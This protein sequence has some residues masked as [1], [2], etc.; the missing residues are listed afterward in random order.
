MKLHVLDYLTKLPPSTTYYVC[1]DM[2][3]ERTRNTSNDVAGGYYYVTSAL[4]VRYIFS[5]RM[6]MRD[7]K[8]YPD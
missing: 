4:S 8:D 1:C 7:N 3:Y 6:R 2:A 5:E